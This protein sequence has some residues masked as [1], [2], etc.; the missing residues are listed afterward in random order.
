MSLFY[1]VSGGLTSN[2]A[3][4]TAHREGGRDE[5]GLVYLDGKE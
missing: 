1:G 5:V 3:T 2:V 4:S